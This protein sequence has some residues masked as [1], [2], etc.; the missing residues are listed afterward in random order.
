M[1][2]IAVL[3]TNRA[4]FGLLKPIVEKLVM[5]GEIDTRL[6]V[7]GAHLSRN[8]GMT[9]QEIEESGLPVDVRIPI[10]DTSDTPSGISR[11]M[12]NALSSFASYF[13]TSMPDALLV[14]GDRTEVLAVCI[15]AVNQRIPIIH[16]YGGETTE[17]AV[18]ECVRHSITK[19]SLFH[20]TATQEYR[21]R[22]IQLGENPE[23]VFVVGAM[24][25]ENA[26]NIIPLPKKELENFI[27]Q[28]IAKPLVVCTFH[29]VT[30]ETATAGIQIKEVLS[31]LE[32]FPQ[33]FYLWTKSNSDAGGKMINQILEE[34]VKTH[35]NA[36]LVDSL[37]AERYLSALSY[38]SFVLG[39]SSSGLAEV[40][41]FGIPT[42]NIGDR[43]KG[44]IRGPSVI[45]CLPER[46]SIISAIELAESAD[47]R[48]VA[49]MRINPYGDGNTSSRI[50]SIISDLLKKDLNI[51]KTFYDI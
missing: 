19:M 35:E 9:V 29:P 17:G 21:R 31:A 48:S 15:A 6:I 1:K 23:R 47:F 28:P 33:N 16:L 24:G 11:T 7:T 8:Y 4:D 44:R 32:Q 22:V 10:L 41:S 39:N 12:A 5:N 18:D 27:N 25:V 50:V 43:Q 2:K 45:D 36:C 37:G 51:K 38:A 26:L 40:P 49:Q 14:L 3:T 20:F 13:E 46:K 30:L 42:I 34:F